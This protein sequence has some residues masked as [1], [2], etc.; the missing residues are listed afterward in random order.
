MV[1]PSRRPLPSEPSAR[2]PLRG[3]PWAADCKRLCTDDV[4][5]F[6]L[7]NIIVCFNYSLLSGNDNNKNQGRSFF[8]GCFANFFFLRRYLGWLTPK[9]RVAGEPLQ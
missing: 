9:R 5:C 7:V 3:I 8:P 1:H 4:G 6:F 2:V